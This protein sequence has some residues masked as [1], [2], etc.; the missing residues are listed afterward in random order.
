VHKLTRQV[1]RLLGSDELPPLA[2]APDETQD[3]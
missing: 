3:E 2:E 1:R